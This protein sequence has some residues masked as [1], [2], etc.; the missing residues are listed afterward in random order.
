[1]PLSLFQRCRALSVPSS[2]RE[3]RTE[4]VQGNETEAQVSPRVCF[5]FRSPDT[6]AKNQSWLCFCSRLSEIDQKLRAVSSLLSPEPQGGRSRRRRG[7]PMSHPENVRVDDDDDDDVIIMSPEPEGS[8][9]REIPLKIRC[10]TEIH[11][12]PV[13]S[14]RT[15]NS[16]AG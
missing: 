10:R 2:S 11:K 1:M 6:S 4:T 12:I 5:L 16:S 15:G 7:P 9:V 8:S 13:L 3:S 14:V